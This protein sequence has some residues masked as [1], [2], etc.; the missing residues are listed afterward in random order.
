MDGILLYDEAQDRYIVQELID[1]TITDDSRT[2][3][4]HCGDSIQIMVRMDEWKSTRIE[5]DSESEGWYFV[6]VGSASLLRGH[7]VKV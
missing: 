2:I 6:D 3:D 5:K 4:L 7:R 1:H